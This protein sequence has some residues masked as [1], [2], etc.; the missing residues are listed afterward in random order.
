MLLCRVHLHCRRPCGSI[1]PDIPSCC[2]YHLSRPNQDVSAV[3]STKQQRATTTC[4]LIRNYSNC[5]SFNFQ[6]GT[7][8]ISPNKKKK[9]KTGD[10]FHLWSL[11]IGSHL[12]NLAACIFFSSYFLLKSCSIK[13]RNNFIL[14][15]FSFT[16]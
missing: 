9:K 2:N 7:R 11:L 14:Y 3:L 16:Y 5:F 1:Y 10:H 12:L 15:D 8:K 13:D 6:V 4:R